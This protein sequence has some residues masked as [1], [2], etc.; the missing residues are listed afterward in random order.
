MDVLLSL[1][2]FKKWV[3]Q[4]VEKFDLVVI[5]SGSGLDVANEAARNGLKVAIIE[6]G[7][8]GGTCLNRGCIPSKM[9][10]HVAD[11]VETMRSSRKFSVNAD[12]IS[13]DFPKIVKEV[14]AF[15]DDESDGIEKYLS[16]AKNPTL[17]RGIAEFR[18][19]KELMVGNTLIRGGKILIAAGAR[20]KIPDIPGLI[21]AGYLTSTEALRLSSLP[22]SLTIIGG[23]YIAVELAH[24]FGSIGSKVY[25]IQR[26]DRL[27]TREDEEISRNFTV[28]FAKKHTVLLSSEPEMITKKGGFYH[29]KVKSSV[30]DNNTTI[31]TK[32]LLI[33][34]GVTPNTDILMPERT[35]VKLGESGFIIVDEYLET[36][37]KGIFSLGDVIGSYK[38]KHSANLEAQYSYYNIIDSDN[39]I[40]VNYNAIPHAVFTSPQIAG[41]GLSEQKAKAMK[42]DFVVGKYRYIDTG[43]GMALKDESGF[44]KILIEKTSHKILGCHIMGTDASTL[45]HEVVVAMNAG[46]G[47]LENITG[48][49]HVHPALSEV[50]IR[51]ALSAREGLQH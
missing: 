47:N 31:V 24:F 48:T 13:V 25:L 38:L 28:E 14:S 37:V 36:N 1:S 16:T 5:G 11:L 10:L 39:K 30:E 40:P 3:V 7:P 32:E 50:V 29:V 51:A 43:M 19:H 2:K 8:L 45:L 34:V 15:V 17:F 18:G 27:L 22:D 49:V 20:P 35:G 12:N 9:L 6:S 42:L 4:M 41:V 21:E 44:V 33:A 23:G 46:N 26:S